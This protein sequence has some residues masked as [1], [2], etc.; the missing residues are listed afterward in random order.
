MMGEIPQ[1]MG[2]AEGAMRESSRALGD[3]RPQDSLPAQSQALTDMQQAMQDMAN[4]MAQALNGQ[5]GQDPRMQQ[6]E[7]PL[8]RNDGGM[9]D[10]LGDVKI[11]DQPDM[12]R[13][14]EILDELRRRASERSRPKVERDYIERLLKQF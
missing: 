3:G 10:F 13:A 9:D 5:P 12:Q 6:G 4:A 1:A 2:R 11:P 14:Q 7:D 8:G